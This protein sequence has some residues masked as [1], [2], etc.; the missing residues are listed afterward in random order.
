MDKFDPLVAEFGWS[1]HP[2]DDEKGKEADAV[3]DKFFKSI[4]LTL[5]D[6]L[7]AGTT[8]TAIIYGDQGA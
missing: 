1:Y 4:Q 7:F 8:K 2:V 5:K 3:A 6:W